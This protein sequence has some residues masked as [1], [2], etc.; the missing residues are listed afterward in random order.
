M[1]GSITDQPVVDTRPLFEPE[2]VALLEV[3][4][5]LTPEQW[6]M[7]TVCE[8]WSVHDVALHLLW[9]DLSNLSRRRDDYFGRP[10]DNPGDFDD[11]S[12]L[13][14][15][16]NH[17]NDT[18]IRGAR[19][20]SPNLL[21]SLLRVTGEE[22]VAFVQTVDI[23]AMG[24]GVGWAGP[25]PAPVWL[26]IAREFTERWVHQQHIRDAAGIPGATEPRFLRPVLA[27]FAMAMPFALR[28]V[29]APSGTTARLEITGESGGVWTARKMAET[30]VFADEA[31][32]GIDGTLTV[33]QDSAWRLFTRGIDRAGV[34][35]QASGNRDIAYA[36]LDMVTIL[37]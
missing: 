10:Q 26:D 17:L 31:E 37:A 29:D 23:S 19:R 21:Q 36:L 20:I 1:R 14:D 34:K 6:H 15:F 2:R 3:L 35:A 13:I 8:G 33:D 7:P 28:A 5:S 25:E 27:T 4:A 11:L 24:M 16:V 32:A 9:G 22:W 18:W 30:W 12:S